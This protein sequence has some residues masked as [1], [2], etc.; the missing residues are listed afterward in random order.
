MVAAMDH[1]ARSHAGRTVAV[2]THGNVISLF[3]N[4]L[5]PGFSRREA[6]NL[7]NPDLLRVVFAGGATRWD[8]GFRLPGLAEISTHHRETPIRR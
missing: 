6:E 1:I 2:A 5:D 4:A 3:L 7:R 8:S